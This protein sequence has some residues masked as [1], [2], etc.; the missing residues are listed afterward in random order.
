MA[1]TVR[2][3]TG[4]VLTKA[5]IETLADQAEHGFDLSTWHPRPGRPSLDANSG[6][7]SP[8]IAVRVPADLQLRVRRKANA[9]GR[10]MSRVLR[11]LLEAYADSPLR[12]GG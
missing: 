1:Q 8:R 3:R 10:S 12:K 4:R 5:D 7:H 11:D 9:E 6:A 2:T